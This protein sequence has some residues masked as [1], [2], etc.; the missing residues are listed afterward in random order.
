MKNNK[1]PVPH[2]AWPLQCVFRF[3]ETRDYMDHLERSLVAARI[4]A[5]RRCADIEKKYF[6]EK[7]KVEQLEKELARIKETQS[8][9]KAN[10]GS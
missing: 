8:G 3:K 7:H 2:R 1:R 10:E 6:S 4:D 9:N 5:D